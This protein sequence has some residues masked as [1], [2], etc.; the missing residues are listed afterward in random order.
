MHVEGSPFEM[1]YNSMRVPKKNHEKSKPDEVISQR[2]G[3]DAT[4][5]VI[6]GADE[7]WLEVAMDRTAAG[8]HGG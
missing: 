2:T 7:D 4:I 1:T 3:C 8:D 6:D 5:I